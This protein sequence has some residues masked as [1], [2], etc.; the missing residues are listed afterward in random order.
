MGQVT[1]REVVSVDVMEMLQQTI[2]ELRD[3]GGAESGLKW[4]G[5]EDTPLCDGADVG[6]EQVGPIVCGKQS[7]RAVVEAF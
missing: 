3:N 7:M 4:A 6:D 1:L 2:L 5:T